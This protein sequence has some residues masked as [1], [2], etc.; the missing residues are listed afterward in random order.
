MKQIDS[1]DLTVGLI[2]LEAS[3]QSQHDPHKANNF[4]CGFSPN[5]ANGE[6]YW[7]FNISD[8]MQTGGVFDVH[9]TC[10]LAYI[11][12][13]SEQLF[14]SCLMHKRELDLCIHLEGRE[15]LSNKNIKNKN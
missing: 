3:K 11:S 6:I 15:I 14:L 12:Y 2:K 9:E 10:L 1:S 4:Y 13:P 7:T 5:V 8:E